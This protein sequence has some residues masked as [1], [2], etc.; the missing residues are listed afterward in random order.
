MNTYIWLSLLISTNLILFLIM[1]FFLRSENYDISTR[2]Y[3]DGRADLVQ[4]LKDFAYIIDESKGFASVQMLSGE[5]FEEAA[6]RIEV[7]EEV[8]EE[9]ADALMECDSDYSFKL[10]CD[11]A[12]SL[13]SWDQIR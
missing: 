4:D 8:C 7:L 3:I 5:I 12:D 10:K 2:K 11:R 1:R 9:L 13:L 6:E